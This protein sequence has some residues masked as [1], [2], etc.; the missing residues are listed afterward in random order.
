MHVDRVANRLL[1]INLLAGW[2]LWTQR[3]SPLQVRTLPLVLIS[4][5]L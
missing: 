2:L 3:P 1:L 4:L 5:L